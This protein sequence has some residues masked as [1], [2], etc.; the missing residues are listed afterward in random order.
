MGFEEEDLLAIELATILQNTE[1]SEK[2]DSKKL[3]QF[4]VYCTFW[5]FMKKWGN[6]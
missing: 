6:C 5:L 3:R 1:G 2:V 4:D